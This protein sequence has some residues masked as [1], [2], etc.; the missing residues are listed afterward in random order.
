M[1][2]ADVDVRVGCGVVVGGVERGLWHG[3]GHCGL[4]DGTVW[5]SRAWYVAWYGAVWHGK[6]HGR[7]HGTHWITDVCGQARERREGWKEVC[8]SRQKS[9][10]T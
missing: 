3:V 10:R 8:M 6:W 9:K 5:C 1:V 7:L 4:V 2:G